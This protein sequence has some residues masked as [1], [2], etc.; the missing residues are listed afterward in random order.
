MSSRVRPQDHLRASAG[1]G[2]LSEV[3]GIASHGHGAV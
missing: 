3:E 2:L 1:A